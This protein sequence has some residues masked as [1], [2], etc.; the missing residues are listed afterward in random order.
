MLGPLINRRAALVMAH[1]GHELRVFGWLASARALVFVLTDG[2]GREGKSRLHRTT[3]ILESLG[4]RHGN[5]YGRMTDA[6]V[7]SAIL[8]SRFDLFRGLVNELTQS[9]LDNHIEY[10]VADALEG[11]NPAHDVCRAL[12]NAA[13]DRAAQAGHH[14]ENF[15]MLLNEV[16]AASESTSTLDEVVAICLEDPMLKQ[17]MRFARQYREVKKEVDQI[18]SQEGIVSLRT[19][20]LRRVKEEHSQKAFTLPPYY[21]MY[22][23]GQVEAGYYRQVIRYRDHFLPLVAALHNEEASSAQAVNANTDYK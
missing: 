7:Y 17:K 18:I 13:V 6:E 2:S 15:D 8:N 21:E 5:I 19:E 23:A 12:V 9:F 22:G 11:F 20:R 10:V 14:I 3:E 4:A 1:P 16:P